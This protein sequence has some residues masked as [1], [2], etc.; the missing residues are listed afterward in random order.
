M[1]GRRAILFLVFPLLLSATPVGE[2]VSPAAVE[3]L[4]LAP[5]GQPPDP[6][7]RI[8]AYCTGDAPAITTC[9]AR[10]PAD[11]VSIRASSCGGTLATCDTF[12]GKIRMTTLDAHTRPDTHECY[13]DAGVRQGCEVKGHPD[14][15]VGE[16]T[17]RVEVLPQ[18][19]LGNDL[20][21]SPDGTWHVW[22][23]VG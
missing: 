3:F 15:I 14:G 12:T 4:A 5:F 10:F 20:P 9:E 23:S 2:S 21:G 1:A 8:V 6:D 13:F 22:A 18:S 19:L 11:W 7:A 17:L 16:V